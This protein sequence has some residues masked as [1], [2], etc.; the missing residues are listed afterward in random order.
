MA[1]SEPNS[2][3][4]P[5]E[6]EVAR[7]WTARGLPTA[8]GVLGPPDGTVLHQL[9]GSFVSTE[10]PSAVAF[11]AVAA[12]VEARYRA[13]VG[14][15]TSGTLRWEK[16]GP[17]ELEPAERPLL[18]GLGIWIGGGAGRPWDEEDRH[19]G[20]ERIVGRLAHDGIL[21]SRD[22]PLRVCPGCGV[23][24]NPERII[25]QEEV[26]S[27][28]LV[29]FDL[30]EEGR[31]LRALVWIDTPWRL[32]G[33]T[34][35]LV[36][37]DL[38]YVV[39]RYRRR[40]AEELVLTSR[41]S[42]ARFREWIPDATFEVVEERP[43]RDFAGRPYLYPLRHEFPI[44]GGLTPPA[45]TVIAVT[46][47][48]D[49]GTGVVPL[50]P[51]HGSTDAIIAEMHGIAGWPLITP[52]GQMDFTLVHKYAG[53]DLRTAN[54]FIVRDLT[55]GSAIFAELRVRR[56]VPHCMLCGAALVWIP[57]RAWCLEPGRLPPSAT[58][59]YRKVLPGAAP[60]GGVEVAPWP[61][62]E[63][64]QSDDRSAVALLECSKCERLDRLEGPPSC[65][66]G[67]AMY[68]IRRRLVVSAHGAFAAWA[69]IGT[70][71]SGDSIRVYLG[72]RR[73]VPA[74]VHHLAALAA[75]DVAPA[76]FAATV[77][78]TLP[79]IDLTGLLASHGADALR[80]ALLRTE[81][82][83]GYAATFRER[84]DQEKRRLARLAT[85]ADEVLARCDP[86]L[87]SS[88]AQPV[89]GF[90]GELEE[91]D[92]ALLARWERTRVAAIAA[93]DHGN[94]P[95]VHR[96]VFR[97][98]ES[99]LAVYRQWVQPRLALTGT[100]ASKRSALRTLAHVLEGAAVLLAPIAPFLAESVHRRFSSDRSSVF[101]APVAAVTRTLLDDARVAAWDRWKSVVDA[102][103]LARRSH[104]IA[105]GDPLP[106]VALVL[107]QDDAGDRYRADRAELERL[108][109]V[110]RV[111]VGSPREPWKGRQR[112]IRPIESEIQRAYPSQASQIVHLLRRMPPRRTAESGG[113]NELS[114]VIQGLS[115]RVLP[116]MVEYVES[117]PEGISP[118]PWPPGELYVHL[119][120][121]DRGDRPLPPPLSPDAFW[122]VRHLEH[123]LRRS[124]LPP[125][126][127]PV[128]AILV[129]V[130]PLASEV[131]AVAERLAR[132]LG[133]A[134]V[135]V[136]DRLED[137]APPHLVTGRTRS[138]ARW[139]VHVPGI[140]REGRRPK[141]RSARTALRRVPREPAGVPAEEPGLDYADEKVIAVEESV[142]AFNR[143]LDHLLGSPVLGPSK[144]RA[145]WDLGIHSVEE[146]KAAPFERLVSVPGFGRAVTEAVYAGVGAPVRRGRHEEASPSLVRGTSPP[147]HRLRSAVPDPRIAERSPVP[148]AASVGAPG[149]PLPEVVAPD[150]GTG[151]PAH[152]SRRYVAVPAHPLSERDPDRPG[153]IEALPTP[154]VE[155]EVPSTA[156]IESGSTN[157]EP[158]ADDVGG[159]DPPMELPGGAPPPLG[160]TRFEA[161]TGPAVPFAPH[162]PAEQPPTTN[163]G[164]AWASDVTEDPVAVA[165]TRRTDGSVEPDDPE[166][167]TEEGTPRAVADDATGGVSRDPA[168]A[169]GPGPEPASAGGAVVAAL[170]AIAPGPLGSPSVPLATGAGAP[171]DSEPSGELI[172]PSATPPTDLPPPPHPG[173]IA[174]DSEETLR[175]Q[176]G[177]PP[178]DP[179]E[180]GRRAEGATVPDRSA[181]A[182]APLVADGVEASS[183]QNVP[184]LGEPGKAFAMVAGDPS[185]GSVTFPPSVLAEAAR[186][187]AIDAVDRFAEGPGGPAVARTA[188]QALSGGIEL[189]PGAS[190]VS[191]LQPFLEATS[192]G[193]RGI[194]IVRESPERISAQIGAR[195]VEV[196]WLTNYGKGR[197]LRP[198]D[199]PGFSGFLERAILEE[200]VSVFFLEGIEYLVRVHGADAVVE[201]LAELD[202]LARAHEA[203]LW[204]QLTESLLGSVDLEKLRA[205]LSPGRG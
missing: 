45:G 66:C 57:G 197:T 195:P 142:R 116:S 56:G 17:E 163:D 68:P 161:L 156:E 4:S 178:I 194:V 25:Y 44:G 47:V 60:L 134:E 83:E 127:T 64:A 177:E 165:S 10:D 38:P 201:R 104:G 155:G 34:A 54:E 71:S 105:P 55:E 52:R 59:I 15:R 181:G 91:E 33:T 96:R 202:R 43:G 111:E 67:G 164:P 99:D 41:A 119:P 141:S 20:V 84:A 112:Q 29:R 133:L 5:L 135:R 42:L 159:R 117:L 146:L 8:S 13:L 173:Q 14:R 23:P 46:D 175:P 27:T 203:R 122:L 94:A 136:V 171:E 115:R 102:V 73:K 167:G 88:F 80:A 158:A 131:Q 132:Y 24:R 76:D 187:P 90:F 145:V 144:V 109:G 114:V 148:G 139:W 190:V 95:V 97:F 1:S 51:G 120:G 86:P 113:G 93:Y 196:F 200:H 53:L 18:R 183:A 7:F 39:A 121:S 78:P 69:R 40:G 28:Y 205:A 26:G 21:V 153:A 168:P 126:G 63:T 106:L 16:R 31:V 140:V 49:T 107:G 87:L 157:T 9:E 98:L 154:P 2:H 124:S 37:P 166:T 193:L 101:E 170:E 184:P 72:S 74:L 77:L 65:S 186:P 32:L 147:P 189:V 169:S 176:P 36:N 11:R 191:S 79:E 129:A 89:E 110:D 160:V 35:V 108:A 151:S 143:E 62:S 198:G 19:D 174:P 6:R 92:R 130:D 150:L 182:E 58:E 118:A 70:L 199:L 192:A 30:P 204:V 61:I 103:A 22:L 12:D 149:S 128:V 82:A 138:G 179:D 123:R 180:P 100:P 81:T 152:Y 3:P 48:T 137:P 50:V 162:A 75:I 85:L 125:A 172:L 188:P 185:S